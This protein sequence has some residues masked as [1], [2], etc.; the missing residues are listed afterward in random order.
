MNSALRSS[1]T[2]Q[3]WHA[4]TSGAAEYL[5]L[6]PEQLTKDDVVARLRAARPSLLV[7]D[8]AH[9]VSA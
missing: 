7:V 3:A 4:V 6:S 5:F 2:R 8:E 1:D 9:C